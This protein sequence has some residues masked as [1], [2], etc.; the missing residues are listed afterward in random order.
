MPRI[1]RFPRLINPMEIVIHP[2]DTGATVYDPF[3]REPVQRVHLASEIRIPGQP[4]F[5][6]SL[7][8]GSADADFHATGLIEEV[9]GYITLL[10]QDLL[11]LNYVP[12]IN[13]RVVAIG[14]AELF[15]ISVS[16]SI[17][18]LKPFC[19]MLGLGPTALQVYFG[20][21]KPAEL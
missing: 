15:T 1:I 6:R 10:R 19:H 5:R 16:A 18:R 20:D 4:S 9:D 14:A 11:A 7:S 21:R 3:T 12:A 2:V 17:R 8:D 13:D